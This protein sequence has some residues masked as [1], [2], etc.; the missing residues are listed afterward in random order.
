VDRPPYQV[1]LR[2][3][4]IAAERWAEI[5][6][7]YYQVDLLRL[8]PHKFFNHLWAWCVSQF[9]DP[10]KYEEW[11]FQMESP[12]EGQTLP[13]AGNLA[14]DAESFDAFTAALGSN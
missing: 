14:A 4:G 7:H 12:L 8:P 6:A 5:E 13:T 11:V 2:L 9:H 10:E 3:L 1:A